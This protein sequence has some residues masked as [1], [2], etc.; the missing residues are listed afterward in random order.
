MPERFAEITAIA[1]SARCSR[2]DMG[3]EDRVKLAAPLAAA[4]QASRRILT[5]VYGTPTLVPAPR[6]LDIPQNVAQ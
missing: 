2:S 3:P 6:E 5:V 4:D 1:F